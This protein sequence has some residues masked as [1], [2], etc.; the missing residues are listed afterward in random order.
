MPCSR[1]HVARWRSSGHCRVSFSWAGTPEDPAEPVADVEF[2]SGQDETVRVSHPKRLFSSSST[3]VRFMMV[4]FLDS[5]FPLSL[6]MYAV[7]QAWDSWR[8]SIS[9]AAIDRALDKH[10]ATQ[11]ESL[12]VV[13]SVKNIA[14]VAPS[15]T[16]PITWRW[17]FHMPDSPLSAAPRYQ[18]LASIRG[19]QAE[20]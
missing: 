7:D 8:L 14:S 20:R 10:V 4:Q 13:V 18:E 2:G 15:T 16:H 17:G 1:A 19:V 9:T 11:F 5:A 6:R 12:V 3:D